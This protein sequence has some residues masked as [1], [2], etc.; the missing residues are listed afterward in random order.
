[1]EES[2]LKRTPLYRVYREYEGVKFVDFGGWELP[3]QFGAGI[4]A[5]HLAVRRNAGLF[6]VSH[7]GEILVEGLGSGTYLNELLTNGIHCL[8]VG[9]V[10]YS[11]MCLP[12]GGTVDDLIVYRLAEERYLV[13]VNASNTEKDYL[14]MA[15]GAPCAPAPDT[16]GVRRP[17]IRNVS[18]EYAQLA[19]QGPKAE[20][21][22]QQLTDTDLSGIKFFRFR[23]GVTVAGKRALVSRTGYTGEDG[24]ELYLAPG[25][26]PAV[27]NAIME[28]F[29]AQG[30]L[31]CGLGARDTLRFEA[32]L[33]LYGNELSDSISP[34][35]AGLSYFV[36]F[37][38]ERFCGREALAA[39]KE[40]G[41]PRE[42]RGVEMVDKAVARHGYPVLK[43][44][45]VIGTVT[46]GA[47]SPM[48]DAF[49]ALVLVERGALKLGE[50]CGIEVNGRVR[51]A[52]VI[53]TPFYK[54][55]KGS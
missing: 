5:E 28:R 17:T 50:E 47:K 22:L 15:E 10:M 53:K 29:S 51:R 24:F 34:L 12:D 39:L 42:L 26:A 55:T 7:M 9:Q 49:L 43:D 52:R 25:D 48:L 4:I 36:D 38:K 45:R 8:E 44:G 14:W 3:V 16:S 2:A 54:H 19:F 21:Y 35:E 27:W 37:E 11:P 1:M 30:V 31:P 20:A 40:R 13:V 23:D 46:S 18:E 6:D 33:P 41:A 32:K